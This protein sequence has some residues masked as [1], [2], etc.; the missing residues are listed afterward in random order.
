[1]FSFWGVG[2][3]NAAQTPTRPLQSPPSRNTTMGHVQPQTPLANLVNHRLSDMGLTRTVLVQRLGYANTDKGLR[4]F[5]EFIATGRITT[6]LLKGLPDLLGLDAA[7]L[8]AA[9]AATRQQIEDAQ[10][11]AA[12]ERFR[13]HVLVQAERRDGIRHGR[14]RLLLV[15]VCPRDLLF[16]RVEHAASRGGPVRVSREGTPAIVLGACQSAPPGA[17]PGYPPPL[18]RGLGRVHRDSMTAG[19]PPGPITKPGSPAAQER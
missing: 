6:H 4:R 14:G 12:R 1:M 8:D 17:A 19:R 2:G 3:Y 9:A 7:N 15:R 13:P 11:A 16:G 18:A 10:D 5:D